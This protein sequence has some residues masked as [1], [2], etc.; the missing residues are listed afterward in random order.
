MRGGGLL[1]YAASG[2][3]PLVFISMLTSSLGPMDGT[4]FWGLIHALSLM[5]KFHG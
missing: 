2:L 1:E 3:S 5:N 4:E